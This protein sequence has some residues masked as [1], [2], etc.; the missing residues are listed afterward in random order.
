M[1]SVEDAY[2]PKM[3]DAPDIDILFNL[4]TNSLV[5][6]FNFSALLLCEI[7]DKEDKVQIIHSYNIEKTALNR[8]KN[9][10]LYNFINDCQTH[11]SKPHTHSL[12][13][14]SFL[15]TLSKITNTE[16][17]VKKTIFFPIHARNRNYLFLFFSNELENLEI[18]N[19]LKKEIDTY[20][21][22]ISFFENSEETS[23]K[24]KVMEIYVKEIGHDIASSVQAIIS[25]LRN[26][27]KGVI[28][29]QFAIKKVV[30]AEEEIMSTYRTADTLGITVDPNYNV[31]NGHDFDLVECVNKSI[32]LCK[33][34]SKERNIDIKIKCDMETLL[35]WG[36]DKAI[37]SAVTQ[38]LMNAIKYAK[39][40][41]FITIALKDRGENVYFSIT[42][43]GTTVLEE[44]KKKM[45]DFGYRGQK[46]LEMHVNGSG[47]GLYTVKKIISA[48]AGTVGSEFSGTADTLAK[49]FFEIPKTDILS[50]T[51][52]L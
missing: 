48:H 8:S 34:E 20:I 15:S 49:F 30:E 37:Q 22:F 17:W 35:I 28:K 51:S 29:G 6:K 1:F 5:N 25:K 14:S 9:S 42:N 45:W 52:L 32:K 19:E 21:D 3:G 47:I 36:D 4:F 44:E 18:D 16:E 43:T 26:V 33:S 13:K 2:H 50:R 41:S 10:E 12:S 31:N 38:L 23:K 7:N 40:G 46:A 24:L 27:S 11:F 39:G